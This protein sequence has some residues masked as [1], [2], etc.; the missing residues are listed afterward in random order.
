MWGR[1]AWERLPVPPEQVRVH[2][3]VYFT[4]RDVDLQD[5]DALVS[6]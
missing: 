4:G 5:Q 1:M 3:P 6:R 2:Y